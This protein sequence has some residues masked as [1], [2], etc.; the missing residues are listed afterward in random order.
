[1]SLYF[2]C[3]FNSQLQNTEDS[4]NGMRQ[5]TDDLSNKIREA[6]NDLEDDLKEAKDVVKELKDFLSGTIICR[7]T[8]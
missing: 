7:V 6:R 2:D 3:I 1:M 5:S 8:G 4:T